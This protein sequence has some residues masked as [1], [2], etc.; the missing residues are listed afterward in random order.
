M[1]G[2]DTVERIADGLRIPGA[3]LGLAGRPWENTAIAPSTEPPDGDD[4][5]KRRELLRGALA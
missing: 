5:M 3:L 4:P 1:A 2:F